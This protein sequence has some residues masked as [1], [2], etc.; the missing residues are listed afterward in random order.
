M[1]QGTDAQ[2]LPHL[3][4]K[5]PGVQL[6]CVSGLSD[7]IVRT[8]SRVATISEPP[9]PAI[10]WCPNF[11]SSMIIPA[12]RDS[13]ALSIMRAVSRRAVILQTNMLFVNVWSICAFPSRQN[14][15]SRPENH[16]RGRSLVVVHRY[17]HYSA[18]ATYSESHQRVRCFGWREHRLLGIVASEFGS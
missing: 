17:S 1:L 18:F 6:L 13:P 15:D 9:S 11:R 2:E 7:S 16:R 3:A 4:P 5:L 10:V 14:N 12:E 8:G